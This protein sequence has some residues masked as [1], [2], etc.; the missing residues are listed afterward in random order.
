[1]SEQPTN[2]A[3][4]GGDVASEISQIASET[5][6]R[7]SWGTFTPIRRSVARVPAPASSSG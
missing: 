7:A 4:T 1:M 2:G 6:V 3:P 5:A